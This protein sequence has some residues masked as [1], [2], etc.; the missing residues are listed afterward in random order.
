MRALFTDEEW[1]TLR[2]APFVAMFSVAAADRKVDDRELDAMREV[3]E[4]DLA[5]GELASEVLADLRG[6]SHE[7]EPQLLEAVSGIRADPRSAMDTLGAVGALLDAK[8][9][10]EEAYSF[11]HSLYDLARTVARASGRF[12]LAYVGADEERALADLNAALGF[13][14][15]PLG[16]TLEDVEGRLAAAGV[17]LDTGEPAILLQ[18]GDPVAARRYTTPGVK[19]TVSAGVE[20]AVYETEEEAT[21][22]FAKTRDLALK[23]DAVFQSANVVSY[24]HGSR[25]LPA[26]QH[27]LA[28]VLGSLG[29]AG[30]GAPAG[31][32]DDPHG[33]AR[34][35]YWD[36][37]QWTGHTA[38]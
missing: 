11:K 21:V 29:P 1:T 7:L 20:V 19:A 18:E 12:G 28:S 27:P 31:W 33:E 2:S 14:R 13:E 5:R 15:V 16:L 30:T 26:D 36:G 25:K 10:A 6:P 32:Y 4:H 34:L 38:P 23:R 22:A 37:S 35:R 24:L 3:L 8:V 17:D 9:G